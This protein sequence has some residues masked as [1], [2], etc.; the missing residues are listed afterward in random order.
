MV[1]FGPQGLFTGQLSG[2]YGLLEIYSHIYVSTF[3]FIMSLVSIAMLYYYYR[4]SIV[5]VQGIWNGIFYTGLIG[6]G[7]VLEHFFTDV[8]IGSMFH[9]LHLISAPNELL[10]YYNGIKEIFEKKD[11]HKKFSINQVVFLNFLFF[12]IVLVSVAVLSQFSHT[13][14]DFHVE[15]PFI[16]F[17]AIPTLVLVGMVIEKSKI[18]TE[19]TIL[20]TS[21][22]IVTFGVCVLTLSILIGRQADINKWANIYIIAHQTQNIFHVVIGTALVIMVMT[23]SQV[24]KILDTIKH[25]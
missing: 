12:G 4:S 23:L 5:K 25:R 1:Q 14:W 2:H 7:E 24:G 21:L 17:T 19:S 20:L 22:R 8:T 3:L 6:L 9:Y 16:I 15:E 11:K 18:I 10:F 13:I